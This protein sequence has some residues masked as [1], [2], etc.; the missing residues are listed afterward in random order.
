M[1]VCMTSDFF[2][3]E[4]DAWRDEVWEMIRLHSHVRFWLLT[5]RAHRIR[6]CLS[7]DWLAGRMLPSM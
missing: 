7:W 1:R 2:L 3:E 6:D 4:A 5:K